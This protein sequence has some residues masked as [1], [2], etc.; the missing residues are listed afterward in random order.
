MI[1]EVSV[2]YKK[3]NENGLEVSVKEV[4]LVQAISFAEAEQKSM[5]LGGHLTTSDF[6]I[7][8]IKESAVA[9]VIHNG[10]DGKF[11]KVTFNFITTDQNGHD[12]K[13]KR[14]IYA[15]SLDLDDAKQLFTDSQ[16]NS[17][18]D[19]EV[20]GVQETKITEYITE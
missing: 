7:T 8:A 9:D 15:E 1:Y 3:Q 19:Y 16:K 20:V 12:K 10:E 2:A 5:A 11:F 4:F 6:D 17:M 13:T 18:L 14:F